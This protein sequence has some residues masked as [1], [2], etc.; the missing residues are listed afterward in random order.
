MATLAEIIRYSKQNP[1]TPYAQQALKLIQEGA[2]DGQAAQEGVDLSWAGRPSTGGATSPDDGGFLGSVKGAFDRR[3]EN[4]DAAYASDQSMPSKIFQNLGQGAGLLGD[5][6]FEGANALTGGKLKEG[7]EIVGEK[8]SKNETARKLLDGYQGWSQQ[9]PEAAGNLESVLNISSVLPVAPVVGVGAR[10]GKK[11]GDKVLDVAVDATKT[12]IETT[13]ATLETFTAPVKKFADKLSRESLS[14]QNVDPRAQT[15]AQR[16]MEQKPLVGPGAAKRP[17]VTQTYKDFYTQEEKFK[18]DIKEDTAAGLVGSRIGDEFRKVV[19]LRREAG[20]RMQEE[21]K[22]VGNTPTKIGNAATDFQDSLASEGLQ[23]S[24]DG[25]KSAAAQ[26]RY[27]AQDIQL[28]DKYM[29]ELRTLSENPTIGDLD[30]FVSRMDS[31]LDLY[32]AQNHIMG[33]TP[34][35][36]LVKVHLHKLRQQFEPEIN[37][38][39]LEAYRDA[40]AAYAE[41]SD[42]MKEGLQYLGKETQSGDFAK[43]A[44]LAKSAV[45]SLLNNGKKDWLVKLEALTGYPAMDESV[46]ALQAMK[47][48]GNP[49][50]H[51]LLEIFTRGAEKGSLPISKNAWY[52]RL[53]E[54]AGGKA[55]DK[56][57]GTP[58]EQTL[59][60][61]ETLKSRASEN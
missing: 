10:V 47:D 38:T 37:G 8:V 58:N 29:G 4:V 16:I 51:S 36:R 12:G 33:T 14:A 41:L 28:F 19:Q 59:R 15:S 17:D 35:E 40:R 11:V 43:D 48:A 56:Y 45:Q 46:L 5:V 31:E 1:D 3:K 2:F 55:K 44:S 34:G 21:L 32:K 6:L 57:L 25:V 22:T 20:K 61:L 39:G 60:F 27:T 9:H 54:W 42:F 24:D 23:V 7:A 53:L 30:A 18:T 50:G 13:Q 52:E 49:M 26:S